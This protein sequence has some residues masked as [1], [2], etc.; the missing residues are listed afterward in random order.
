MTDEQRRQIEK[1]EN[2]LQKAATDQEKRKFLYRSLADILKK[3]IQDE[4]QDAGKSS[5]VVKYIKTELFCL[6]MISKL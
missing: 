5:P 6:R 1:I 3:A 4:D 2:T